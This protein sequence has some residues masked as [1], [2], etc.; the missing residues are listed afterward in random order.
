MSNFSNAVAPPHLSDRFEQALMYASQLHRSQFRKG[1]QIPYIS[2]LLSVTALVLEAGGDEDEA[3]AALLHDA[4]EDQGGAATR[5][6]IRQQFGDRVTAIV[7]GCTDCDQQPKPPWYERKREHLAQL[8]QASASVRRVTL[9]DKLHNA[10]S[11]LRDWSVEGDR[12]W[13]KFKTGREGTLWLYRSY[14]EVMQ[15]EEENW[16]LEELKRVVRSLEEQRAKSEE[17]REEI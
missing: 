12:V 11:T 4:I 2:H 9:A 5:E 16:M 7:D 6:A 14:I 15:T 17:K 13:S 1:M 10:R 3:I 8:R